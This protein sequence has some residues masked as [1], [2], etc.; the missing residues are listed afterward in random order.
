MKYTI[1]VL[2]L[3]ILICFFSCNSEKKD[4]HIPP[5]SYHTTEKIIPLLVDVH[6]VES[7]MNTHRNFRDRI[8]QDILFQEVLDKHQYSRS[9]FDSVLDYL[10]N[11]VEYYKTVLDSVKI[12]IQKLDT[13]NLPLLMSIDTTQKTTPPSKD[14]K[15]PKK[16]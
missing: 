11:N 2:A 5:D 15:T 14:Q 3:L 1:L 7:F 16:K 13:V 4:Q 8:E 6:L 10:E 12:R 9:K